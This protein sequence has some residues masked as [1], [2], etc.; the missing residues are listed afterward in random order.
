MS[1]PACDLR[2]LTLLGNIIVLKSL[3]ASQLVYT[4]S[5]LKTNQNKSTFYNLSWN[6]KGDKIK[7]TVIIGDYID[8]GL[9]M[10]DIARV[11]QHG[12]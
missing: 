5:H 10:L 6:G 3:V 1:E 2:R 12:A 9:R 8:G 7:R 11:L 4:L